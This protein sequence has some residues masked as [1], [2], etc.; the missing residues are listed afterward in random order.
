MLCSMESIQNRCS[1]WPMPGKY[2][3]A[4][5]F[6]VLSFCPHSVC[7]L[8]KAQIDRWHCVARQVVGLESM[9]WCW[10]GMT[11]RT[12][13]AMGITGAVTPAA[14]G[15]TGLRPT[16]ASRRSARA[17]EAG[18][19]AGAEQSRGSRETTGSGGGTTEMQAGTTESGKGITEEG[20][21]GTGTTGQTGASS[22]GGTAEL[23]GM[24]QGAP[25]TPEMT[26]AGS[27]PQGRIGRGTWQRGT[28]KGR[29]FLWCRMRE[30]RREVNGTETR[31][32]STLTSPARSQSISI[33]TRRWIDCYCVH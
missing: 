18:A 17:A 3:C 15:T 14:A 2:V 30:M 10:T 5:P 27:L 16:E 9:G 23:E 7:M 1:Q 4:C 22:A 26:E 33:S 31:S 13:T 24:L 12:R 20:G 6:G 29:A 19:A 11:R 21:R 28:T 8:E 32:T 25:W